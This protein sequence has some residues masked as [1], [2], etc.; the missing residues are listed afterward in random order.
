[1]TT[2]ISAAAANARDNARTAEGQF[3]HQHHTENPN[4]ALTGPAAITPTDPWP[5]AFGTPQIDM[6]LSESR[7]I[8]VTY[9]GQDG[10][11]LEAWEEDGEGIQSDLY[12]GDGPS[13][14]QDEIE[15]AAHRTFKQINQAG[16]TASDRGLHAFRHAIL[17]EATGNPPKDDDLAAMITLSDELIRKAEK[18]RD[19]AA[20]SLLARNIRR[21]HPEATQ[22]A[23][24]PELTMTT[25]CTSNA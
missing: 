22:L 20:A 11:I 3:G 1:M 18:Q 15:T 14:D 21:L 6:V 12:D 16:Q 5:E 17:A 8:V 2:T 10:S 7:G 25:S 24:T 13:A 19:L 9:Q 4:V 23:V